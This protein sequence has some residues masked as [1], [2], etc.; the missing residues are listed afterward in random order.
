MAGL[1][2][3]FVRLRRINFYC[4]EELLANLLSWHERNVLGRCNAAI[5]TSEMPGLSQL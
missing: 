5:F 4:F 3:A 2:H 1:D